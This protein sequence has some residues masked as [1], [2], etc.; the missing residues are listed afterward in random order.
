M[1]SFL[2]PGGGGCCAG[3]LRQGNSPFSHP[4]TTWIH[5][6]GCPVGVCSMVELDLGSSPHTDSQLRGGPPPLLAGRP[7]A[8]GFCAG[9]P[10]PPPTFQCTHCALQGVY[11]HSGRGLCKNLDFGLCSAAHSGRAC[12]VGAGPVRGAPRRQAPSGRKMFFSTRCR[13]SLDFFGPAGQD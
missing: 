9:H 13:N 6:T 2:A 7:T 8:A 11:Q 1:P 5:P 3:G 12:Q 4:P 10:W